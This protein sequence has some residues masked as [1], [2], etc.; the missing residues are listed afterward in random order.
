ML[1]TQALQPFGLALQA[2]EPLMSLDRLPVPVVHEYLREHRLLVLRGFAPLSEAGMRACAR[3]FGPLL[4]WEFGEIL[5][6]RVEKRPANHIF[7]SGRVEMHWDGAYLTEVPRYSLFQCL[8]SDQQEEGGETLFTDAVR[9]LQLASASERQ[10]WASLQLSYRTSKAAHYSGS[11]TVPLVGR[12]PF[13]GLPVVRFIEP[14]NEDNLEVNPVHVHVLGMD[15][16]AEER[17]LREFTQR[18]YA[19]E[20]MYRHRWQT[21]DF[22]MYDNH[23]LLHGRA[24]M[25]GNI[26]R[27]LQ[28]GHI[29][30]GPPQAENRRPQ[31]IGAETADVQP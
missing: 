27:H 3:R 1:H 11:V 26:S 5:N 25:R 15:G 14:F 21:G 13:T 28:R 7:S 19:P 20:V 10:Q 29:L 18:L 12:H 30:E 2:P 6:L 4:E 24:R 8:H 31:F 23:A 17:F 22:L 9:L 16:A